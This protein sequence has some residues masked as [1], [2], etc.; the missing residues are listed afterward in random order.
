MLCIGLSSC[1]DENELRIDSLEEPVYTTRSSAFDGGYDLLGYG[2]DMTSTYFD[3]EGSGMPVINVEKLY[4]A[5]TSNILPTS[6][7][8]GNEKMEVAINNIE[9]T[10]NLTRK[11][12]LSLSSTKADSANYFK[13]SLNEAFDYQNN[14]NYSYASYS[15]K[16]KHQRFRITLTPNEL[17]KFLTDR[18]IQDV[19]TRDPQYIIAN[20]GTH[21][22]MDI[23]TGAKLTMFYRSINTSEFTSKKS[24]VAASAVATIG[25]VFKVSPSYDGTIN[26]SLMT[27]NTNEIVAYQSVGGDPSQGIRGL[28][29]VTS[30]SSVDIT[31]W[32][33]SCDF[34]NYPKRAGLIDVAPSKGAIPIWEFVQDPTKKQ[35][36][37][38]AVVNYVD[39]NQ[40][41]GERMTLISE[42]SSNFKKQW[43][44]LS[45]AEVFPP[46]YNG[47]K[48]DMGFVFKDYVPGTVPLYHFRSGSRNDDKYSINMADAEPKYYSYVGIF[49]YVYKDPATGRLPIQWFWSRGNTDHFYKSPQMSGYK[50]SDES[51]L[52]I[53]FYTIDKLILKQ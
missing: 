12:D 49:C 43:F 47:F 36:I 2:Y 31:R 4:A 22:L 45:S 46:N 41:K 30:N 51:Y 27:K 29:N 26:T 20:Y 21:V 23:T 9:Y 7:I 11:I 52:G 3:S 35:Q 13:G 50:V 44:T 48:F 25:K 17:H 14:I 38:N 32:Q 5:N 16:I 40:F 28:I 24:S 18:F 53:G 19:A 33:S 37:K 42:H 1:T 10:K 15:L 34:T 39:N 8:K 6:L